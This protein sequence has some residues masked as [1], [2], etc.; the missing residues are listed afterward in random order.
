M[1]PVRVVDPDPVGHPR[2]FF[3]VGFPKHGRKLGGPLQGKL[4]TGRTG[5]QQVQALY[6][7]FRVPNRFRDD[8][9]SGFPGSSEQELFQK[10]VDPVRLL[11]LHPVAASGN[12]ADLRRNGKKRLQV[13][14]EFIG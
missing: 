9:G 8:A 3:R 2:V 5:G 11:L 6:G 14:G 4:P 1:C 10:P 12:V 13:M 7:A